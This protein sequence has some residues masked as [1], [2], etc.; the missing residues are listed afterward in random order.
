METSTRH[1]GSLGIQAV[2]ASA[3]AALLTGGL[4]VFAPLAEADRYPVG[5]E[6]LW[7]TRALIGAADGEDPWEEGDSHIGAL[8]S[9]DPWEEGD[10]NI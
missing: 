6:T 2:V 3:L 5:T 8:G 10:G 7:G 9:E 4:A 1:R